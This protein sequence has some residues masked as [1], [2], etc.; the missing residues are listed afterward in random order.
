[1]INEISKIIITDAKDLKVRQSNYH[2]KGIN[3]K[4]K[5]MFQVSN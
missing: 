2:I 5:E 4:A 3:K 1:M